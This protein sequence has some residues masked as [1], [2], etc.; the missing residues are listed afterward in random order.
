MST[1]PATPGTG[2]RLRDVL[3]G[4]G[5]ALAAL[6]TGV[7]AFLGTLV[8]VGILIAALGQDP[9][10]AY[11]TILQGALGEPD[12]IGQT[13]MVAVPLALCGVAAAIPFTAR[14]W[15][16]GAEGQMHVGAFGAVAIGLTL[17]ALPGPVFIPLILVGAMAAGAA[18]AAIAGALKAFLGS[19]EVIVTLMLNFIAILL[20]TYAITGIWPQEIAP[21]TE[22]LP[23]SAGLPVIWA[24]TILNLGFLIA[25]VVVALAW[26]LMR[27]TGTG[28]Q[29]RS[30]GLNPFAS[31]M[32]GMNVPRLT[33]TTFAL[34]GIAAGLAGAILVMGENRALVTNFSPGYGYLG[35]AVALVA[36]LSAAWIMPSAIGFAVLQVGSQSLPAQTGISTAFGQIIIAAFVLALL[37]ARV[38]RLRYAEGA[39][40]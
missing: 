27:R 26:V 34:A 37:G 17:P 14:L 13:L 24:G 31:R 33:V 20:T 12:A 1:A 19:N 3:A 7:V 39:V 5:P 30:M 8:A 11:R 35:I 36:R 40:Q 9:L 4:H 6:R 28:L 22:R 2:S 15:N 21:Q 25:I 38:I 29:I 23:G 32:N 18:W 16:I 10:E